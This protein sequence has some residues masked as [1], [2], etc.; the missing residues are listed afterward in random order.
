M[1]AQDGGQH[2]DHDHLREARTPAANALPVT[3]AARGVGRGHQLRQDAGVA[4]PDDLDAVEDRD[5]QRRLGDDARAPGSPGTDAPVGMAWICVNVSPKISSHSAGWIARVNSS[6]R[7][8]RSFCSSTRQSAPMRRRAGAGGP[9]APPGSAETA[10]GAARV[11]DTRIP[12]RSLEC[13]RS[14][15][16]KTSSRVAPGPSA[17]ATPRARPTR[18]AGR[19]AS[20]P[21]GRRARRPPPCSAS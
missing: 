21:P 10:G 1:H 2:E 12:L 8:W 9:R 7:S 13:R 16:R 5:E 14:R 3:S 17:A 6:V 19:G 11:T 18:G 15:A 4:L 20:G